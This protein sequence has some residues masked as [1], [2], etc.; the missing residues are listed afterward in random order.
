MYDLPREGAT[1]HFESEI[2]DTYISASEID[3]IAEFPCALS[4]WT[5]D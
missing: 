4:V 3:N 1:N 2:R 5:H